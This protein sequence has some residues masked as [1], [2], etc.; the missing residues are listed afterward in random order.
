MLQAVLKQNPYL[1]EYFAALG[2]ESKV[3]EKLIWNMEEYVLYGEKRCLEVDQAQK[4]N[5]LMNLTEYNENH[6]L[7][8]LQLCKRSLKQTTCALFGGQHLFC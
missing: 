6:Q 3:S 7:S 8:H 1:F 2:T 4:S 5:F